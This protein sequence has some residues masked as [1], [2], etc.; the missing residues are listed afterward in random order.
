MAWYII[1]KLLVY[2]GS[3]FVSVDQVPKNP[4]INE[5]VM[6]HLFVHVVNMGSELGQK[7]VEE[8]PCSRLWLLSPFS[9]SFDVFVFTV[10]LVHT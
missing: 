6:L 5:K 1:D 4:N 2:G 7:M 8:R 10:T 3:Y 9:L